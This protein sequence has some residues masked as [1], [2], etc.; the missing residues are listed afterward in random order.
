MHLQKRHTHAPGP[1]TSAVGVV[2]EVNTFVGVGGDPSLS[3]QG[4]VVD[5]QQAGIGMGM[6][7]PYGDPQFDFLLGFDSSSQQQPLPLGLSPGTPQPFGSPLPLSSVGSPTQQNFIPQQKQQQHEYQNSQVLPLPLD[8]EST[9]PSS[10]NVSTPANGTSAC[11]TPNGAQ[12]TDQSPF[13]P[14]PAGIV[15][16]MQGGETWFEPQQD[17]SGQQSLPQNVINQQ[18]PTMQY[19]LQPQ[20]QLPVPVLPQNLHPFPQPPQIQYPVLPPAENPPSERSRKRS[21]VDR[22]TTD[23]ALTIPPATISN[24]SNQPQSCVHLFTPPA[25]ST[26]APSPTVLPFPLQIQQPYQ[27]GTAPTPT[28]VT[29][30]LPQTFTIQTEEDLTRLNSTQIE[31]YINALKQSGTLDPSLERRLRKARRAIKNRE[32]AQQSRNKKKAAQG[33]LEL[34]LKQAQAEN[35]T[36][37]SLNDQL[38]TENSRLKAQLEHLTALV[39]HLNA[40]GR[41]A[42]PKPNP[43]TPQFQK[44]PV[45]VAACI[46][47]VLFF[48]VLVHFQSPQMDQDKQLALSGHVLSPPSVRTLMEEGLSH[49]QHSM[50]WV[51]HSL[52]WLVPEPFHINDGA[53][54]SCEDSISPEILANYTE[55]LACRCHNCAC[56]VDP[57]MFGTP[58]DTGGYHA[59]GSGR[60]GA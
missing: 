25:L 10:S 50:W 26:P 52:W 44:A 24:N 18:I 46:L 20:Y 16:N 7:I 38:E 23:A 45:S 31:A 9:S 21:R 34:E 30:I 12:Q 57:I 49:P 37:R 17:F 60:R 32:Y 35:A 33:N 54:S 8:G 15:S 43:S 13:Y 2:G 40:T 28:P 11:N 41:S 51:S 42:H 55:R 29:P 47:S 14:D 22:N 4:G 19:Q 27:P 56:C 59:W 39:S 48:A 1:V 53:L 5:Q 6:G 3:Y 36:L 58:H